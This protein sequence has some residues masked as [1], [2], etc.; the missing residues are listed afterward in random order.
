MFECFFSCEAKS[1]QPCHV[2]ILRLLKSMSERD[3]RL[4]CS[5]WLEVSSFLGGF[6]SSGLQFGI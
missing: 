2:G 5:V 6:F 4:G 3:E 1:V